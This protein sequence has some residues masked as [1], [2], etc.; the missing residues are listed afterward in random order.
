MS[1]LPVKKN[2]FLYKLHNFQFLNI[3]YKNT[4]SCEIIYKYFR[5]NY[6]NKLFTYIN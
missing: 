1:T 3:M 6:I 4:A 2:I 5:K